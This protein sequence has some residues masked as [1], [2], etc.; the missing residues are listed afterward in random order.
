MTASFYFNPIQG[1]LTFKKGFTRIPAFG[2]LQEDKDV[3]LTLLHK[4]DEPYIIWYLESENKD[5]GVS[6][7]G[8]GD[9]VMCEPYDGGF[10]YVYQGNLKTVADQIWKEIAVP[11]LDDCSNGVWEYINGRSKKTPMFE[12]TDTSI[13]MPDQ[14]ICI[15]VHNHSNTLKLFKMLEIKILK[16]CCQERQKLK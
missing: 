1:I 2:Q 12:Y 7:F 4:S 3:K 15:E 13:M 11:F 5:I 6:D 14:E 16:F 8:P 10:T 9:L